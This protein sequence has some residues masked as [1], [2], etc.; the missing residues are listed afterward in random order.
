MRDNE[1]LVELFERL[2]VT[3]SF[4]D[5]YLSGVLSFL[6]FA[7]A[8]CA[9]QIVSRLRNE[10]ETQ[11]AELLLATPVGRIR[12]A[13]GHIVLAATAS[14]LCMAVCGLVAGTT[15]GLVIGDVG[16][17]A[18]RVL[19]AAMAQVPAVWLMGA[20]AV[21]LFGAWPRAIGMSWFALVACLLLGQFGALLEFPNWLLDLSP[22][23]HSP[24]LPGGDVSVPKL[25]ALLGTTAVLTGVGLISLVRRDL[26]TA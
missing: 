26:S 24:R 7:A 8:C 4:A 20:C 15:Y 3:G 17:E 9:V 18:P 2:G 13:A 6:A 22:F 19:G 21:T 11:H 12:W 10:E 25:V 5:A 1:N 14:L 23:T 16:D